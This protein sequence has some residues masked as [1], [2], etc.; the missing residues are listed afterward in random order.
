MKGLILPGLA[1]SFYSEVV[2]FVETNP[3]AVKRFEQAS[4]VLGYSLLDAFKVATVYDNEVM[5]CA[6]FV[7]TIA[8]TDCFEEQYKVKPD[9]VICPSFGGMAAAVYLQSVTFEE[10]LLISYNSSLLSNKWFEKM[11]EYHTIFIYNLSAED[12]QLLIENYKSNG[13]LLEVVGIIDKVTAICGKAPIIKK[14]KKEIN[15]KEK[16]ISLYV[17]YYPIHSQ[18]L[19]KMKF[20][21]KEKVFDKV[22]IKQPNIPV[23]SDVS[24]ELVKST[25]AFT[26]MLLDGYDHAV[27]WDL[28]SKRLEETEIENLYI[29]GPKNLFSQL[30]KNKYPT[31]SLDPYTVM[32]SNDYVVG[33]K[34]ND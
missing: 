25:E 23:I 8:L 33:G 7:N 21:I 5:E 4:K 12:R 20:D 11:E 6:F 2:E 13:D 10:G 31:I 19:S 34:K 30:L 28:V 27:R 16:C 1:P 18:L 26:K 24:G 15:R 9:I 3:H 22:E 29:V 14:L 17:M 32:Q